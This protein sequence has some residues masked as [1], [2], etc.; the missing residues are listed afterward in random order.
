[1]VRKVKATVFPACSSWLNFRVQGQFEII[2]TTYFIWSFFKKIKLEPAIIWKP[3]P[4]QRLTSKNYLT[5]MGRHLSPRFT[6]VILVSGYLVLTAVNWSQHW[7]PICVSVF[8]CSNPK[9]ARKYEIEHCSRSSKTINWSA[10]SFQL[11]I[12]PRWVDTWARDMVMGYWSETLLFWQLSIDHIVN[13]IY[14][15][16]GLAKTRLR[17]P[18]LPFDSLPYP[19]RTIC[20]RDGQSRDNHAKRGWPYPMS[21]GL[22]PTRASSAREPRY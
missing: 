16:W 17:H 10:D 1:M 19:T 21:M 14:K 7:C 8:L 22:C 5:T 18:S 6:Q 12:S 15:R 2:N 11:I 13:V 20:R 9:L 4:C 3:V